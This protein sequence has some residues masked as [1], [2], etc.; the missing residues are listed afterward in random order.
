M[1]LYLNCL[2]VVVLCAVAE[3]SRWFR[4]SWDGNDQGFS[5]CVQVELP[6]EETT[7]NLPGYTA[8]PASRKTSRSPHLL[9][10]LSPICLY[11]CFPKMGYLIFFFHRVQSIHFYTNSYEIAFNYHNLPAIRTGHWHRGQWPW[12]GDPEG[13]DTLWDLLFQGFGS[14]FP[15]TDV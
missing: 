4:N 12:R 3:M 1:H 14:Y 2:I 13:V 9:S 11:L 5:G 15:F 8:P 6:E 7:E 10:T